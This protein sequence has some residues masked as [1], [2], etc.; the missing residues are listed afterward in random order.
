ME[1]RAG[2]FLDRDG[3]INE[4]FEYVVS[5]IRLELLPKAAEGIRLFNEFGILVAVVSNQSAVGRGY[6]TEED[7]EEVNRALASLL[8]EHGAKVDAFYYC[9]HHPEARI[10]AY[11]VA[12]PFRKPEPG[13]VLRAAFELRIDP[14]KSYVIGDMA[15]D[16]ELGRRVRARTVLVRTGH[17]NET[18]QR[19]RRK[20][21]PKP[22]FVAED[23]S[24]AAWW[25]LEDMDRRGLV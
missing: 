11:R 1:K 21:V 7:V 4:D 24:E 12:C 2:I 23:L 5:P 19:V 3:T 10:P 15:S 9:P 14:R 16:I 8:Q 20:E 13:M 22:N 18:L 6:C 17:G 25:V